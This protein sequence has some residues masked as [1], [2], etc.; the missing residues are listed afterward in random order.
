MAACR[1]NGPVLSYRAMLK[2]TRQTRLSALRELVRDE[3]S[4]NGQVNPRLV[5]SIQQSLAA[6]GY[7]FSEKA[8][9]DVG[10]RPAR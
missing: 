3:R 7:I 6:E 8:V 9:R 10:E 2:V 4:T 1:R 5:Q